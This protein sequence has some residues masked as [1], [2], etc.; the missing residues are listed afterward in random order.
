MLRHLNPSSGRPARHLSPLLFLLLWAGLLTQA[1]PVIADE[2]GWHQFRGPQRSGASHETG[3]A[4][5]WPDNGPP[6]VWQRPLGEG[7]ASL[8]VHDG[9]LF[10][11]FLEEGREILA[12]FDI[13][14]GDELW[15]QD[16]GEAFVEFFGN[17]PRATPTVDGEVVYGLGS[18]GLLLALNTADGNILWQVDLHTTYPITQPQTLTPVGATP[19]GPQIPVYGYAGSPLVVDDLLVVEAG[20]RGGKSF[21]GLDKHSGQLRWNSLDTEVGY[22]SP[23]LVE[24][25]GQRQIVALPG[26]EIVA[27]TPQGEVLWGHP[28]AWT[29]SQPLFVAPD[30]IFVSTENDVGALM[31]KISPQGE[32]TELWRTKRLKN[33]WN[34]TVQV[35]DHLYGFD[36]ATLRCLDLEHGGLMWAQ[37][38]LGKGNLI[39]A[40]GLLIVLTD[41]GK[42]V[43][44]EASPDGFEASGS[45]Q[46]LSG[47]CWTPP[48]LQDGV[49]YLR[50]HKEMVALDLKP[51]AA[52]QTGASPSDTPQPDDQSTHGGDL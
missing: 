50:N 52:P 45:Y 48:A 1:F 37:R 12:A 38:G 19:P 35:G 34:S 30:R 28:W 47:R 7:F 39:H 49:L 21:L 23:I 51:Q 25:G 26:S 13:A 14:S 33:A 5:S 31:L 43:L 42:V 8:S 41:K 24:L 11:A 17:G 4:R 16:L 46:A 3:L 44:A 27:M 2:A 29:T 9:R 10:T 6:V 20:A 22:A 32:T 40:D 18:R 36:N 15:R